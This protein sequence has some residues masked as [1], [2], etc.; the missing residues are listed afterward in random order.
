MRLCASLCW[1]FRIHDPQFPNPDP[2][3]PKISNQTDAA[4]VRY[5]YRVPVEDGV[6]VDGVDKEVMVDETI[7]GNRQRR[8]E[9]QRHKEIDV[10]TDTVLFH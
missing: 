2:S 7:P 1:T 9:D 5:S 3:S 4:G 8:A 6:A 10:H